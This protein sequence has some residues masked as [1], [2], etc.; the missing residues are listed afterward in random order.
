MAKMSGRIV[1]L[2]TAGL[3]DP[4]DVS[5]TGLHAVEPEPDFSAQY[6]EQELGANQPELSGEEKVK[7]TVLAVLARNKGSVRATSIQLNIPQR[8][9]TKWKQEAQG[10]IV[11]SDPFKEPKQA[12]QRVRL[13]SSAD[14]AHSQKKLAQVINTIVDGLPKMLSKATLPEQVKALSQLIGI[15]GDVDTLLAPPP[16]I[17]AT[18][19]TV[20]E[21]KA[22]AKKKLELKKQNAESEST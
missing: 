8:K 10:K 12:I 19:V 11:E 4:Y 2:S 22:M 20:E 13:S 7:A 18:G 17:E 3:E 16:K 5:P 1:N 14:L 15:K 9:I 6:A 21:L